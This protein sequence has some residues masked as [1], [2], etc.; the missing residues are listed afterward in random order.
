MEEVRDVV[1]GEEVEEV[2]SEAGSGDEEG[3][4]TMRRSRL[5]L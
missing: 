4:Q 1:G 3:M 2:G 5:T